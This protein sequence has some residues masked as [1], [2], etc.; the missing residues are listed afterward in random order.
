MQKIILMSF[1]V[2]VLQL[3]L[4]AGVAQAFTYTNDNLATTPHEKPAYFEGNQT[5]GFWGYTETGRTFTQTPI[6]NDLGF[7]M[8]KFV[9]DEAFFYITDRGII[10][11]PDDLTALSMY[12][13]RSV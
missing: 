7:R 2:G 11:A 5:D 12:L 13:T 8:H 1:G 3:L 4:L 9:I 6:E 10:N